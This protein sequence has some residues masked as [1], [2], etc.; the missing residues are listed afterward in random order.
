MEKKG[1]RICWNNTEFKRHYVRQNHQ[2][3][4][5]LNGW[6]LR[7]RAKEL[8]ILG[9]VSYPEYEVSRGGLGKNQRVKYMP[10]I[11][12]NKLFFEIMST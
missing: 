4:R 9:G 10:K 12:A 3:W 5:K 6:R 2:T 1:L 7:R 11:L 8:Y